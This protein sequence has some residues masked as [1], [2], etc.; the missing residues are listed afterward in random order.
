MHWP[1]DGVKVLDLGQIY[2][3]SYAGFLLAHAGAD[4]VK[5]EP[6]RG[7]ALRARGGGQ[8]PLA[9]SMLN[10]NKRGLA[11][12]LKHERGKALL[13]SLVREADV[14]LENFAPGAL[15]R[16]GVGAEVLMAENPRLVYASGTGYGLSGPAKDNL[17]MDLT[18]QA[19][20]G[21]M[22]VNGP[23][24]GPPLKTGP[25]ICDFFGGVHLY[26]GIVTALYEAAKTGVGRQVEVAMQEAVYPVLATNLT[27]MH[28]AGGVQPERRGNN[29]PANGPGPYNV[30]EC[31][32]GHI[33]I[34][35]VRDVHWESF[36]ALMGRPELIEDPRFCTADERSGNDAPLNEIVQAWTR[37]HTK[38][39]AA[40]KLKAARVPAAPVRDLVEVTRDE[41]MHARGMLHDVEHPILGPVV[42]PTSPLRFSDTPPAEVR[43]EPTL[44]EHSAQVLADWLSLS[45]S[46]VAS[47]HDDGVVASE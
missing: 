43:V 23:A 3:G 4:V 31:V 9:F 6:L 18:V 29:H 35:C 42:L 45:P 2:N 25:A 11:L 39:D 37:A 38:D 7:D 46:D 22:S 24:D 26:A 15:E 10:T 20:S 44:G 28:K 36:A 27:S 16:L 33:A 13:L 17:A 19:I 14:L 12:D 5:V 30:Y 40:A 41:H 1:L 8:M 21:V 47:L 32:D 34:I